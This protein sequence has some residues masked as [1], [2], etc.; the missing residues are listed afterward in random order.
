MGIRPLALPTPFTVGRVNAYL[1]ED[2]P[3]TLIDVGPNSGDTLHA[4]ELDLAEHRRRVEDLELIVIS[5]QHMDHF[6]LVHVLAERSGAQVAALDL[7]APWLADF[8][9]SMDADDAYAEQ[10]IARHGV[11]ADVR[12]V[13][14]AVA[15]TFH[16]WGAAA[17]VTMPLSDGAELKL[18]D[19]T[20]TVHHRPGLRH[21]TLARRIAMREPRATTPLSRS[22]TPTHRETLTP[23]PARAGGGTCFPSR[24]RIC[25]GANVSALGRVLASLLTF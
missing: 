15:A 18:P 5:H 1:I 16:G 23:R 24:P 17:A 20:L 6:G 14:R 8:P 21:A 10:I 2:E 22:L 19:R 4:L 9:G 13:L 3:L 12:S 11:P 7:L 25:D